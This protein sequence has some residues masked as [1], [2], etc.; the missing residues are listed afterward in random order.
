VLL[1]T[2]VALAL[3][4]AG[5]SSG[6]SGGDDAGAV[7]ATEASSSSST[8]GDLPSPCGPGSPSGAP[9]VGVTDTSVTIGYGDDA[10]YA[11]LAGQGH[12]MSDA[13][14]AL[15]SWCNEQGGI[16]GRQVVGNYHDAKVTE[17]VNAVTSA[18][19]ADDFF[20]VGEG[21]I[22]DSAQEQARTGCGLPAVPAY[23]TSAAFANGRL[24]YM[25]EPVPI[26]YSQVALARW[27]AETHPD[28]ATKVASIS[29]DIAAS[30]DTLEKQKA[31]WPAVGIEFLPCDQTYNLL[32]EADWKPF[33]QRL[34]DCGAE[35]VTF[36]GTA[37]PSLENLLE[38]ADQL[39]YHPDW[40]QEGNFY[41]APFAAWNTNG[42][43][44]QVYVRYSNVPFEH[45]S[46]SPALEQYVSIVKAADGDVSGL[47]VNAASAFLLWATAAHGCGN[48]LTRQCVLDALAAEHAWDGGGLS[49]PA[50]VGANL[51]SDCSVVLKLEG[52]AYVQ[53][54]PEAGGSFDCDPQ[55]VQQV[56][57]PLVDKAGLGPDRKVPAG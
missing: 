11:G 33:V 31:T 20:L 30:T 9:D 21:F 19:E 1:V 16:N 22:L 18:C 45:A 38:A 6:R 42:W 48:D 55:N 57:G 3:T 26:D 17:V 13:V 56:T 49:G 43:A 47:G 29:A 12:E 28:R 53:V 32:G 7:P 8:F 10:G 46:D 40:L 27:Y 52:T 36:I 5:C 39:D 54:A 23:G 2:V 25:P 37:N 50:D 15:I 41:E 51:P 4:A 24:V 34:K 44:D 14:E 35:A